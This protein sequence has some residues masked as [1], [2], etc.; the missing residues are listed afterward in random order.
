MIYLTTTDDSELQNL[1]TDSSSKKFVLCERIPPHC[2]CYK[3]W[4][5]SILP[6]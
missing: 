5:T 1:Y 3:C 4:F 2:L 6:R